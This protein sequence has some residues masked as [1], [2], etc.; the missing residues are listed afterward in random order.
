MAVTIAHREFLANQVAS[1]ITEVDLVDDL[2]NPVG[3]SPQLAT[4]TQNGT[5]AELGAGLTFEIT[6][7]TTVAGWRA[8]GGGT[9]FGGFDFTTPETF[10]NDGTATLLANDTFFDYASVSD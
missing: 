9:E 10:S 7:G 6:A 2:G 3:N 5:R 8:R 1:A 4:F